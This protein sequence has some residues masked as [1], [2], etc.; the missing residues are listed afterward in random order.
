MNVEEEL[1][2]L[3]SWSFAGRLHAC[4]ASG[5]GGAGGCETSGG[6]LTATSRNWS[7]GT[8]LCTVDRS[9]PTSFGIQIP[10]FSFSKASLLITWTQNNLEC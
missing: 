5:H 1:E 9:L 7:R 3:E 8:F 2:N 6:V 4:S 10:L